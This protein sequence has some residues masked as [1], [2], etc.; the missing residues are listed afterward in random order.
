LQSKMQ[1]RRVGR[2]WRLKINSMLTIN[3]NKELCIGRKYFFRLKDYCK[4]TIGFWQSWQKI[5][6]ILTKI[7]QILTEINTLW[8]QFWK[9]I[10][11]TP[12][13]MLV[14]MGISNKSISSTDKIDFDGQTTIQNQTNG[15]TNLLVWISTDFLMD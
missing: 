3:K 11:M 2:N 6:H 7:G 5:G 4:K 12:K 15:L 8:W 13:N 14:K 10:Y 9:T 1:S